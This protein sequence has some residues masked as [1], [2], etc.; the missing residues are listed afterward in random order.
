MKTD[1]GIHVIWTLPFFFIGSGFPRRKSQLIPGE[2]PWKRFPKSVAWI[3][4]ESSAVRCPRNCLQPKSH[5][6]PQQVM[7]CTLIGIEVH[8]DVIR[9]QRISKNKQILTPLK[10][11]QRRW[12]HRLPGNTDYLT[13]QPHEIQQNKCQS[14]NGGSSFCRG[15]IH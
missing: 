1:P 11:S 6:F 5:C 9:N 4:K 2:T 10:L 13:H 7:L 14:R 15:E 3:F 8:K 12:Q